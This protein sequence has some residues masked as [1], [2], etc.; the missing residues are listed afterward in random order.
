M[1]HHFPSY[2]RRS[3]SSS[4]VDAI[5][6]FFKKFSNEREFANRCEVGR[7][8][9]SHTH[10]E[11]G[12]VFKSIRRRRRLRENTCSLHSYTRTHRSLF[13]IHSPVPTVARH[14]T[15]QQSLHTHSRRQIIIVVV[16]SQV[17]ILELEYIRRNKKEMEKKRR[18]NK[19]KTKEN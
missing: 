1:L 8:R 16:R 9:D 11:M 2:D 13:K 18:V 6:C 7:G 12:N 3:S 4:F 17:H 15:E 19:K 10:S 5:V 14:A